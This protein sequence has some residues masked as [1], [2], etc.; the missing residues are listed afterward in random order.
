MNSKALTRTE[1]AKRVAF[2]LRVSDAAA[3]RLVDTVLSEI[4]GALCA[5]RPVRLHDFGSFDVRN[6]T[7]RSYSPPNYAR[8][9]FVVPLPSVRF[10]ACRRLRTH[11]SP[12][13]TD[14][15]KIEACGE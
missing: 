13:A 15:E 9:F 10:R 4:E 6:H 12:T 7:P 8:D 1:L 14:E 5:L 3:A 11:L 2:Q